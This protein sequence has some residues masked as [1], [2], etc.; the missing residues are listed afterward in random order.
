MTT[1]STVAS[2]RAMRR[3]PGGHPRD[4]P[5]SDAC[6]EPSRAW[7]TVVL[8]AVVLTLLAGSAVLMWFG[9]RSPTES[10]TAVAEALT[11]R[12]LESSTDEACRGGFAVR[13]GLAAVQGAGSGGTSHF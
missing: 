13:R 7:S 5:G 4:W 12:A 9:L 3:R 10:S 8:C 2:L 1:G 11:V 6:P